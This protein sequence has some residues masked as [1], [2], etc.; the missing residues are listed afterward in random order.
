M[1]YFSKTCAVSNLPV[2]AFL[3]DMPELSEVVALLPNG[4]IIKGMYDGYGRINDVDL[5]ESDDFDAAKFVLEKYFKPTMTYQ[6]LPASKS[7]PGQGFFHDNHLL[8]RWLVHDGFKTYKDYC[9][10]YELG[11]AAPAQ[12]T[13][14]KRPKSRP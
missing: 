11:D 1:G 5:N 3:G 9:T 7:D 12:D 14:T 13:K 10:A 4:S 2:M 6:S 8:V